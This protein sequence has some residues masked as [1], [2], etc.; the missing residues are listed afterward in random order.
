MVTIITAA[1][2][3]HKVPEQRNSNNQ[4]STC[5]TSGGSAFSAGGIAVA[6][7]GFS[8]IPV[9]SCNNINGNT[10]ANTGNHVQ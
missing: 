6:F 1:A 3:V 5:D 9:L 2:V 7:G 10:N 8:G 4:D